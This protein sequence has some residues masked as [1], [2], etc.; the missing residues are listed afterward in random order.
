MHVDESIKGATSGSEFQ[1]REW[2]GTWRS[3]ARYRTGERL[4]VFL[5]EPGTA[6]LT[7]P[8]KVLK[9]KGDKVEMQRRSARLGNGNAA[10]PYREY[11]RALRTLQ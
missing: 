8:I 3:G 11:I 5:R 6:G 10:I 4:I 9:I 1:W 7:S 2:E